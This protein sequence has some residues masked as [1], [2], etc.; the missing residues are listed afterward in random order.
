MKGVY[1]ENE[2]HKRPRV[3]AYI[4][5]CNE[6]HHLRRALASVNSLDEIVVVDS[7]ST[8]KTLE[9]A[10]SFGA[11]VST[12]S[13]L[14]YA[15]Q[16]QFALSQ[17]TADYVLNLDADE[18][19]SPELIAQLREIA[20]APAVDGLSI[21][22][23]EVFLGE[24]MPAVAKRNRKI[25]FFRREA[26]SYTSATVHENVIVDGIVAKTDFPIWH[27]G[28]ESIK[29]KVDKINRY[30]TLRAIESDAKGR[31][32]STIKLILVLPLTLAKSLILRRTIFAGRRGVIAAFTNGFYAFLKEAKLFELSWSKEDTACSDSK[33]AKPMAKQ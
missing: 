1:K 30:S 20:E 9:I 7:G 32:P 10:R 22:I 4:I 23:A 19:A 3:G 31:K 17:C 21:P 28:E 8:D 26:G 29:V 33:T 2:G 14:G 13:W 11:R 12:Q 6:E 5:C 16:K 18:A 24:P 25:R 15:R 27:F